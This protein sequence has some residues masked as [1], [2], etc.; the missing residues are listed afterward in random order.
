MVGMSRLVRDM[1]GMWLMEKCK[2]WLSKALSKFSMTRGRLGKLFFCY[3]T[4]QRIIKV[5]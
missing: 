4:K 3:L 1:S 5:T 2:K